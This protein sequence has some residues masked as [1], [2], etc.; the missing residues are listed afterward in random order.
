MP[1]TRET[2]VDFTGTG[3]GGIVPCPMLRRRDYAYEL[4][5]ERIAQ[6]P[7]DRRDHSRLLVVG[8]QPGDR[9]FDEL[10]ELLP[11]GA[12]VVVNDT[13]VLPARLHAQK[14]T[15]GAV[16]LLFL[17]RLEADAS[18]ER[19][20]CLARASKALRPGMVLRAAGAAIEVAAA[21]ADDGAIEVRVPGAAEA[22]LERAGELPLPPYIERPAGTSGA[23]R[24][25]YQTVYARSP[26]AVAAPTAGLHFT[27][28]LLDRLRDRGMT[29]ATL[30]LHVGLGTFAPVRA[31][32]LDE[33]RMHLERY[34]IPEETAALIASGRPVVAVGT[35]VVRALEAAAAAPRAVNAGPGATDLFI[36]PGYRFQIVDHLVTNFHLPEST[37]M[38]LVSAFA[39]YDRIMSAYRHAI[40]A[41][42]RFFSFGDAMLL[43]RDAP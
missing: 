10:P 16:E 37:L 27:P 14:D 31:D 34:E 1:S 15:G 35:T 33:H 32:H 42:Y 4:P 28:A 11:P 19:W 43:S 3:P 36:R 17:E 7:S 9:R 24:E 38:V 40:A 5:P 26:G 6:V 39:G 25:R 29:V 2:W 13:R 22:L 12:V 21:R 20:R 41:D 23:D 18:G 8:P 30:T